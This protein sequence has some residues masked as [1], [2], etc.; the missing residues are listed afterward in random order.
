MRL[1]SRTK[2]IQSYKTGCAPLRPEWLCA[3][4]VHPV[5]E[6]TPAGEML[7]EKPKVPF[8]FSQKQLEK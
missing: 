8:L 7:A 3:C 2:C 6:K 5:S 4:R 1:N